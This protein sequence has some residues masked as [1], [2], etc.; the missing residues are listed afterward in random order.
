MIRI[1]LVISILFVLLLV[2]CNSNHLSPSSSQPSDSTH[3]TEPVDTREKIV[4]QADWLDWEKVYHE[5]MKNEARAELE[6]D[7]KWVLYKTKVRDIDSKTIRV[8]DEM[9]LVNGVFY[10]LNSIDVYGLSKQEIAMLDSG[11]SIVLCGQLKLLKPRSRLVNAFLVDSSE[12]T[13]NSNP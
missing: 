9:V 13:I 4:E 5:Y 7:G 10:P 3:E 11:Q 1:R 12:Q 2:G 6:Y 8:S